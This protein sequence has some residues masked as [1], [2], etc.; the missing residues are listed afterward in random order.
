LRRIFQQTVHVAVRTGAVGLALQ[1][2]EGTKIQAAASS[3][4]GWSKETMEKL[5]A[6]LDAACDELDLKVVE[7]NRDVEA[8]GYRLT[9]GL[10]HRQALRE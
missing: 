4:K 1:A 2:L 6:Q 5:L 3:P 9:A 7:E 8:P 10:A